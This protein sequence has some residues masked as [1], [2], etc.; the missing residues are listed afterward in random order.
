ML[1]REIILYFF[2]EMNLFLNFPSLCL[3]Y[4]GVS[5]LPQFLYFI[6]IPLKNF[7]KLWYL[8][9]CSQCICIS[10]M[11]IMLNK[12]SLYIY[13]NWYLWLGFHKW[14]RRCL[15]FQSTQSHFWFWL[16]FAF[17][18]LLSFTLC[19]YCCR[20][21]FFASGL[22]LYSEYLFKLC[23]LHLSYEHIYNTCIC[24]LSENIKFIFTSSIML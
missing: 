4:Q 10:C 6:L 8:K 18:L 9:Y 21:F 15:P 16:K 22:S 17:V 7:Q 12:I 14:D 11:A 5:Y 19:L 20:R 1:R 3:I 2:F 23:I 13:L 24:T